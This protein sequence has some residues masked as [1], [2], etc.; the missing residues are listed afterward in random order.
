MQEQKESFFKKF[1][2]SFEFGIVT[3]VSFLIGIYITHLFGGGMPVIGG[4]WVAISAI[5]VLQDTRE[6][7]KH[8]AYIR[9]VGSLIGSLVAGVVLAI[10]IINY[11]VIFL[12]VFLAV[13]V[14]EV[15]NFK[16]GL[17]LAALTSVII[18]A[19]SLVD[20][21]VNFII[22]VTARFVE[23]CCGSFIAIII[24]YITHYGSI[25]LAKK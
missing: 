4:L 13:L 11:Y 25:Y 16:E 2:T 18:I 21:S 14:C 9:V 22:N 1:Y 6:I 10:F 23:S 15:I 24:R 20:P 7:T 12:I 19:V 17:R 3:T 8:F 5:I